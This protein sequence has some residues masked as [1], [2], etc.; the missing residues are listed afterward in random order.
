MLQGVDNK[1][2]KL[3]GFQPLQAEILKKV[4]DPHQRII[5][6]R[7]WL[8]HDLSSCRTEPKQL[9]QHQN[10]ADTKFLHDAKNYELHVSTAKA[11]V[12]SQ[13]APVKLY[14]EPTITIDNLHLLII[15]SRT[16]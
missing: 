2:P 1:I 16:F 11:E 3:D 4:R 7:W 5:A 9:Q 14:M 12:M 8:H 15:S 6:I 10:D 13:T